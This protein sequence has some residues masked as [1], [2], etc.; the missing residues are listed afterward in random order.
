[1]Q[2]RKDDLALLM[3]LEMGKP[4]AEA[5]GE[6]AYGAEFL[7]WFAEEAVR[8]TGRY[9][10][11]PEGTGR[12]IVSQHPVG[13]VLPDHPLELPARDGDPEDRA[14]ARRRLHR[15]RQARRADAAHDAAVAA[16]PRRRPGCPPAC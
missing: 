13:P 10:V 14:G 4:L 8:I 3:T 12:T 15:R 7:R 2:E 9:G 5:L 16:A 11:N 1:M 6:V